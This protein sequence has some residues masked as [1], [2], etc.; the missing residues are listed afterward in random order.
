MT[1]QE[2]REKAIEEIGGDI[3]K[4]ECGKY[5]DCGSCDMKDYMFCQTAKLAKGLYEAGYRKEEEVRKEMASRF[6]TII[7]GLLDEVENGTIEN[8]EEL[9]LQLIYN[10]HFLR[11][12]FGV[13]V[14]E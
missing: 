4:L 14:E 10:V 6:L 5:H 1:E 11:K 13:E 9:R 3:A 7:N 2:K 12:E 8:L